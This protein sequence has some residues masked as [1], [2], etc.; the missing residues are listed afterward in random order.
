VDRNK[1]NEAVALS[2]EFSK[3]AQSF[4]Y[5]TIGDADS[6]AFAKTPLFKSIVADFKQMTRAQAV[7]QF[8]IALAVDFDGKTVKSVSTTK[9]DGGHGFQLYASGA[10]LDAQT[11]ANDALNGKYATG[12]AAT[13]KNI[14]STNPG[15]KKV[16]T[17]EFVAT[18]KTSPVYPMISLKN[19]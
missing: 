3:L 8:Q 13:M 4:S 16:L 10:N 6:Q 12:V 14:Y 18:G 1:L 15:A 9:K 17:D 2:N 7:D 11:Q 19:V 5:T